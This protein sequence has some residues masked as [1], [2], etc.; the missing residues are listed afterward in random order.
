MNPPWVVTK[1]YAYTDFTFSI[2]K[3]LWKILIFLIIKKH[4]KII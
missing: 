3:F 4:N 2:G 1:I